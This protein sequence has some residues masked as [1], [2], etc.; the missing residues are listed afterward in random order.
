MS[1]L[2]IGC[3]DAK[4]GPREAAVCA[5]TRG[6][7]AGRLGRPPTFCPYNVTD[8][9]EAVLAPLWLRGYVRGRELGGNPVEL[10]PAAARG[11]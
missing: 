7:R 2:R 5:L 9:R 8:R 3:P 4:L 11:D 10:E 6:L 1:K